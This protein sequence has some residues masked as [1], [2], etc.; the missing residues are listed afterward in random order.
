VTLA[1]AHP[2]SYLHPMAP[3]TLFLS[4]LHCPLC[5]FLPPF[6]NDLGL[7]TSERPH[8]APLQTGLLLTQRFTLPPTTAVGHQHRQ[9]SSHDLLA[10][11]M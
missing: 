5:L 1:V 10:L 11:L 7:P 4:F 8:W 9:A 6:A 3:Y 2:P